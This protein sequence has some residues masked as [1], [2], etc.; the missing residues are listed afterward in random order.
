MYQKLIFLTGT[1]LAEVTAEKNHSMTFLLQQNFITV[2]AVKAYN[3]LRCCFHKHLHFCEIRD[4]LHVHCDVNHKNN[5]S[6]P[7]ITICTTSVRHKQICDHFY[8][9]VWS[10]GHDTSVVMQDF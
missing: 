8:G 10:T 1:Q 2:K 4:K 5:L 3:E 7:A 6:Y 9:S